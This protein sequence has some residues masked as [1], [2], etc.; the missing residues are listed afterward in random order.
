MWLDRL[1]LDHDN[2]R[3]ALDWCVAQNDAERANGLAASL[4]RFWQM[5]GTST[6][7]GHG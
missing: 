5:R 4:W 7:E 2:F 3:A 1:E 6:K